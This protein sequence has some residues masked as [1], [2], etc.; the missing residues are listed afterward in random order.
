MKVL[1]IWFYSRSF[2]D[3]PKVAAV[4]RERGHEAWV[5]NY[6]EGGDIVWQSGE[7]RVATVPGPAE[8]RAPLARIPV[9]G[10][11]WNRLAFVAFMLRLR[12]FFRDQKADI[13]HVC[14]NAARMIWLLPVGMPRRMRFVI[15]YRQ[16]AQRDAH[17]PVGRLKAALAH[18]VRSFYCRVLYDRA[19]FLHA[20]GAEK[21]LGDEWRR[22]G[23]VVPL[24]VDDPFLNFP[25]PAE[26]AD[27][28]VT[29]LYLGSISRVRK[30]EQ[31][32][33]AVELASSKAGENG[34]RLD[35]IGPDT[36]GGYYHQ[37][38]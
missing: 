28:P 3:Y 31:I 17:G 14:P 27:G 37:V 22:W 4:L 19:T 23:D 25:R 20:L 21:V 34:F 11:L 32:M 35:F 33:A 10:A 7:E 8:A 38:V 36:T 29:F 6:D 18:G 30:L 16:I 9:L 26:R 12:R 1:Y 15:D 2:P 5:A 24:A 13:V